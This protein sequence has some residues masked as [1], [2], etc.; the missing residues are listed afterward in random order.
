MDI[1][2]I[3]EQLESASDFELFR[4]NSAIDKV[5]QDPQR[6]KKLRQKLTIGMHLDYFCQDRNKPIACVVT[7]IKRTRASVREIE[8]LKQWSLPFYLLNLDHIET[9]LVSN[10]VIGMSKAELSIGSQVGFFN[11]KQNQ[12]MLGQVMKLNPKRAV[13]LV[14]GVHWT[15]P[16]EAL[17]PIIESET[18]SSQ[19]VL[20]S[21]KN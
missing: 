1:Q 16:Y 14:E 11:S 20:L 21:Q 17:F 9:E 7:E 15:V 3:F 12:E 8:T 6:I 18:V 13:V 5:L 4:L 19:T 10:N 2:R